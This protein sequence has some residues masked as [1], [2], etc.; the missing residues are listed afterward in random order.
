[1]A[2]LMSWWMPQQSMSFTR[3]EP[4]RTT[5][6]NHYSAKFP[7]S[8]AYHDT[9][10]FEGHQQIKAWIL[11]TS[12]LH[13]WLLNPNTS[14]LNHAGLNV[15]VFLFAFCFVIFFLVGVGGKCTLT[16]QP[17]LVLNSQKLWLPLHL[18]CGHSPPVSFLL[19]SL[20]ASLNLNFQIVLC[21]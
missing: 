20:L 17:W 9:L 4:L 6:R 12:L 18:Q 13:L 16:V 19:N 21:F 15:P 1:M 3:K 5:N 10:E 7:L 14:L 11:K 8:H 2:L